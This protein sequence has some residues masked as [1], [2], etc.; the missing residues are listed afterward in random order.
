MLSSLLKLAS[1]VESSSGS[2]RSILLQED[3]IERIEELAQRILTIN[4]K[5]LKYMCSS[6]QYDKKNQM[7]T[8]SFD[9]NTMKFK[10]EFQTAEDSKWSFEME[11]DG[12]I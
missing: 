11:I 5:M 12:E 6:G 9:L 10:R 4:K 7:K 2:E 1:S 3:E 8:E